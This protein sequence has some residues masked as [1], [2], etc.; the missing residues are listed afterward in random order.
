MAI[1][2]EGAKIK[3]WLLR[4][5]CRIYPIYYVFCGGRLGGVAG[6]VVKYVILFDDLYF[7]R[8]CYV[9]I[10]KQPHNISSARMV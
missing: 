5:K 10:L 3:T 8:D 4:Y 7:G 9:Y 6:S 2:K 1:E